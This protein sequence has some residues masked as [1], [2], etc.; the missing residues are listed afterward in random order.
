MRTLLL[1]FPLALLFFINIFLFIYYYFKVAFS[2][3]FFQQT[4]TAMGVVV[5]HFLVANEPVAN[6]QAKFPNCTDI[7]G[8]FLFYFILYLFDLICFFT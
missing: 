6:L 1:L 3:P 7:A 2:L 8:N 5:K 4:S